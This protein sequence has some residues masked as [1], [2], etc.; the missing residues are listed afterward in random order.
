MITKE[1]MQTSA[2]AILEPSLKNVAR[3]QEKLSF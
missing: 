3:P 2:E 1:T